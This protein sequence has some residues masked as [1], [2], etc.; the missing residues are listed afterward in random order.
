LKRE[1]VKEEFAKENHQY[2]R[3]KK[4]HDI[5]VS[6]LADEISISLSIG[7]ALPKCGK[8]AAD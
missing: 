7:I 4:R 2:R 1:S 6:T 8:S 5:L 3:I